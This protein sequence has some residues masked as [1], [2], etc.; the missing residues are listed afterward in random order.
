MTD[1][2]TIITIIACMFAILSVIVAMFL[3]LANKIDNLVTS[4]NQEMKDFHGRL[5]QIEER[6]KK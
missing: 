3:Y 1:W 2:A 6:G 5:C 4:I